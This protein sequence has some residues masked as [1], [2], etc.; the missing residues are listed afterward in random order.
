[1]RA[2]K[3]RVA[4]RVAR[5]RL[6][7]PGQRVALAVSGG[8]DSVCLLDLLVE[9]AGLHGG[10][11]SVVT[12]DHGT[13]PGSAEDAAFVAALA[14][15]RELPIT[16]CSASL[17]PS[18][19][20]DDMRRLRQACFAGLDVDVVALAH[21]RADQ[22]ETALLGWMRGSG[23][24]GL[25][26][27]AWRHG[28]LVRPL[29]DV[30]PAE[31]AAWAAARGL[32]WR[33]D[34]TNRDPRFLRNRVRHELLPLLE[35]LRP[36]AVAA[37]GRGAAFAAADDGLLEELSRGLE[38]RTGDGW[39]CRFIAES[40]EPLVRRALLRALPEAHAG[41]ID[42]IVRAARRGQGVVEVSSSVRVVV[43]RGVVRRVGD[44]RGTG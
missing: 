8:R 39:P 36:G 4:D 33:E 35:D 27:M 20:E 9:S 23:T 31:L 30:D 43:G 40:P 16:V 18:A 15:E 13:R 1:M 21:H 28:R 37:M 38:E 2:L 34:P 14:Q 10:Q 41:V 19:S 32:R 44:P 26:G 12:V 11:L 5:H 24:R 42:A 22:V 6:W 25:A 17:G 3:L 7:E 29:L